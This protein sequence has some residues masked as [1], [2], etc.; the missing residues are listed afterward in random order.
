MTKGELSAAQLDGYSSDDSLRYF[1]LNVSIMENI[2]QVVGEHTGSGSYNT[3]LDS[4][5]KLFPIQR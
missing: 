4:C 2:Y 1:L 3:L 5:S